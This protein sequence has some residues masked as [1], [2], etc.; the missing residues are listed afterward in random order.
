MPG[1]TPILGIRY[2]LLGETIDPAAFANFANDVNSA[3]AANQT[4]ASDAFNRKMCLIPALIPQS[5]TVNVETSITFTNTSLAQRPFRDNDNMFNAGS[6]TQLTI[7]TAGIYM[8]ISRDMAV[9]AFTTMVSI[10]NAIFR[11][12]VLVFAERRNE[13]DGSTSSMLETIEALV[14][15]EAGDIIT[16]RILWNGTGGPATMSQLGYPH[17]EVFRVA[18]LF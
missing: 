16:N 5:F 17:L 2:P 10:R 9:N 6:P 14:R 3:V 4:L 11:N 7:N 8:I 12:G 13:Q 1:Q 18:P 15:C